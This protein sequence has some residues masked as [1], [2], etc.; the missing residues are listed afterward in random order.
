MILSLS[1]PVFQSNDEVIAVEQV[2]V[3]ENEAIKPGMDIL[4]VT[5]DLSGANPH[6]CPPKTT[7]AVSTAERGH[8]RAL[9]CTAGNTVS[10]GELLALMSS[11]ADEPVGT[12]ERALR[13]VTAAIIRPEMW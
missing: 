6:D 7:Y 13:T 1:L 12:A 9:R 2:C 3:R 5:V 11:T 4:I 10:H 8:V